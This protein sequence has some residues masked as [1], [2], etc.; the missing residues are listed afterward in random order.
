MKKLV[1]LLSEFIAMLDEVEISGGEEREFHPTTIQSCRT[2]HIMRLHKIIPEMKRICKSYE[3][4]KTKP[5]K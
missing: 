5:R 4:T 1:K 3:K 2:H